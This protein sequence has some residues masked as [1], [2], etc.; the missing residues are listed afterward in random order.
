MEKN[1]TKEDLKQ[2]KL[3]LLDEI[4]TILRDLG[5]GQESPDDGGWI[6][7]RS[8]RKRLAVSPGTLQNLRVAGKL[9]FKKVMG[10]YYY[11]A[12]DVDA[13]FQ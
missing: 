5:P 1:L 11:S 12:Q 2:F 4:K 13:F 3:E 7:G 10:T 8:V 6:K 9:R